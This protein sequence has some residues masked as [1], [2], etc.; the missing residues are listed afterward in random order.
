MIFFL[1]L[2][3]GIVIAF[4]ILFLFFFLKKKKKFINKK[5]TKFLYI[6]SL[7]FVLLTSSAI[8]INT[9]N[10]WLGN[11]F[12]NKLFNY[13]TIENQSIVGMDVITNLIKDLEKN[14]KAN[15]SLKQRILDNQTN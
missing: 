2:I 9:S 12:L 1:L 10:Y 8:Y 13:N 5:K 3:A 15:K 11:S 14:L 4:S 7:F 6:G